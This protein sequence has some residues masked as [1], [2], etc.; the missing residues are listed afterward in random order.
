MS[1]LPDSAPF[2]ADRD[3]AE[4]GRKRGFGAAFW[5]MMIFAAACVIAAVIVAVT[6]GVFGGH[7]TAPAAV[8][9]P[10]APAAVAPPQPV[11]PA[12]AP[13][14]AAP[15][16]DLPQD[17]RMAALD[18]RVRRLEDGQAR[19]VNAAAAALAAAT[20]GDAASGPRPFVDALAAVERLTPGSPHVQALAPLAARGAPTR[21]ALAAQL[22]DMSARVSL[23]ARTPPKDAGFMA[24]LGYA[25]ARVV[26]IR[27]VDAVG[28][29]PDALLVR[30][31]RRA[32]DGD[33]E[34][35]VAMLDTLPAAAR[36]AFADWGEQARRRI[37]ID[38]HIAALRAL[39]LDNLAGVAGSAA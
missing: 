33:L 21:A 28:A 39:A 15:S 14:A 27:R 31:Q 37:E 17:A 9:A 34:G 13:V 2:A 23:A 1:V 11:A 19:T 6:F 18:G 35:A 4:R 30:A 7:A 10:P 3:T 25:F 26:S 20:L 24:Q 16:A 8:V 29:G 36:G 22:I 32:A 12:I 5:A 38:G